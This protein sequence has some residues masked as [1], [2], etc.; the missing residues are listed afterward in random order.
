MNHDSELDARKY[1]CFML[2]LRTKQALDAIASGQ[3]LRITATDPGTLNKFKAFTDQT[4]HELVASSE[5]GGEYVIF[6]RKH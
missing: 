5:V 1:G 6:I 2:T 4:G 3:V